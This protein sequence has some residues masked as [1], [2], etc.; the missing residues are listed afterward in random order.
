MTWFRQ[1]I[2]SLRRSFG[3]AAPETVSD[4]FEKQITNQRVAL[5]PFSLWTW[6]GVRSPTAFFRARPKH[7][8]GLDCLDPW[9][10]PPGGNLA[11]QRWPGV[12]Q[13]NA[14]KQHLKL[15]GLQSA[16]VVLH[17]DS[18]FLQDILQVVALAPCN[19]AHQ[20]PLGKTTRTQEQ[21]SLWKSACPCHLWYLRHGFQDPNPRALQTWKLMTGDAKKTAPRPPSPLSPSPLPSAVFLAGLQKDKSGSSPSSC[22][23]AP[24]RRSCY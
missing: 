21:G 14:M 15:P 23:I 1:A 18:V 11:Q 19:S 2:P 6:H 13:A 12:R 10:G 16:A 24:M 5:A 9:A 7:P 22:G 17:F 4:W 20:I 3:L 8:R